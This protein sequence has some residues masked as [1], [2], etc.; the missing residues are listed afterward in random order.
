MFH[1]STVTYKCNSECYTNTI[2]VAISSNYNSLQLHNHSSLTIFLIAASIA[3]KQVSVQR[4]SVSYSDL[5][6]N[7]LLYKVQNIRSRLIAHRNIS[8]NLFVLY[9]MRYYCY[10]PFTIAVLLINVSFILVYCI[11]CLH[12]WTRA[13]CKRL[14]FSI[15]ATFCSPI[16]TIITVCYR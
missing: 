12:S 16:V 6:C 4:S 14:L 15:N 9:R 2:G 8:T 5:Y 11:C 10:L 7:Y 3:L 1:T 13:S